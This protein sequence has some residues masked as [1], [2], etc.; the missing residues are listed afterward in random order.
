MSLSTLR[1]TSSSTSAQQYVSLLDSSSRQRFTV[2][3]DDLQTA[4]SWREVWDTVVVLS[5]ARQP[6]FSEAYQTMLATEGI[7]RE[8]WDHP[9]EDAAWAYL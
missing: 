9:E 7:L 5:E 8:D 2:F 3:G 1:V 4:F 6:S